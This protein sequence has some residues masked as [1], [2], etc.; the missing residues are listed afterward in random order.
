MGLC[1][2]GKKMFD[3]KTAQ[4]VVNNMK[5]DHGIIMRAYECEHGGH[6]HLSSHDRQGKKYQ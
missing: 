6:W 1:E 3:K 2:N 4:T 5:K